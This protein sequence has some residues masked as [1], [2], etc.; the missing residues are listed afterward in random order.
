MKQVINNSN[1][2]VKPFELVA[3]MGPSGCGKTSLLNI[4]ANRMTSSN[5]CI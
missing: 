2:Y 1:G 5:G 3:V 4:F